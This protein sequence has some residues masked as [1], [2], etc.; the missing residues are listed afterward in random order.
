MGK[1]DMFPIFG[2]DFPKLFPLLLIIFCLFT[3]LDIF[4]RILSCIGI[5]KF[6]FS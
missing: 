1:L 3:I 4:G 5:K 2:E 6:S